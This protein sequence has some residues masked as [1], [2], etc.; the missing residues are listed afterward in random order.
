MT[1]FQKLALAIS[2]VTAISIGALI[3]TTPQSFYASYGIALGPDPSLL[4]E[5]RA[6]GAG[7][8]GFGVVMLLGILRPAMSQA[9][10]VA[11]LTVFLAFP[12]GRIL[13]IVADGM[14]SNGILVALVLEL[15]IAAL[16][17]LAFRP[18]AGAQARVSLG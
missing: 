2:G 5:L 14:P 11:A 4:S 15:A 10:V 3:L 1:R 8:A 13:G 16:C 17:V 6:P 7:L 18:G 9:A 12:V